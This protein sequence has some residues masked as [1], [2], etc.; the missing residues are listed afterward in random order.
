MKPPLWRFALQEILEIVRAAALDRKA[1]DLVE[2][3]VAG[4]T[5]IADT[6]VIMTGRSKIQTRSVAEHIAEAVKEAGH[7]VARMEGYSDGNWILLDLG[8]L[9]VHV[10]T[11]EQRAFYNL[12]RL[13]ADAAQRQV[14]SS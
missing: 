12:E 8:P 3:D 6:F 4:K 11:P 5:I 13:W 7:R 10:F 1:E 2:I 14:Q 9:V